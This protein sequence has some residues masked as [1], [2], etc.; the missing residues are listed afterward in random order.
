ENGCVAWIFDAKGLIMVKTDDLDA[1]ELVLE[2]IDAGA[3][4][5]KVESGYVEIFTAPE[6][7]EKVRSTLEQKKI[8]IASAEL[9]KMPKTTVQLEE[10]VAL[11]TLKLLDKLED[12]D[13]VQ[14]VASNIDFPDAILEKYQLQVSG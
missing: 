7:M 13:E 6:E 12:Q 3:D 10:K 4:D 11:Q 2:A 1:D 8:A 5:V 9:A 14:H